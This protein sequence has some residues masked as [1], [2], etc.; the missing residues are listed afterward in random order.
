[1]DDQSTANCA[2]FD[3]ASYKQDQNQAEQT[4]RLHAKPT[5]TSAAQSNFHCSVHTATSGAI[6]RAY[7]SIRSRFHTEDTG[8][9]THSCAQNKRNRAR[10]LDKQ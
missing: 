3:A 4:K 6:C 2:D 10:P 7:V 9:A 1:M 5:H 8:G